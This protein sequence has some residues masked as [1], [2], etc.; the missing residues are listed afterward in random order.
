MFTFTFVAQKREPTIEFQEA[1]RI[2]HYLTCY[3]YKKSGLLSRERIIEKNQFQVPI[4]NAVL[5]VDSIFP[6]RVFSCL[7]SRL[8]NL[9]DARYEFRARCTTHLLPGLPFLVE[10]DMAVEAE[11]STVVLSLHQSTNIAIG[12]DKEESKPIT[13]YVH[14]VTWPPSTMEP[15]FRSR[16]S[17]KPLAHGRNAWLIEW[18]CPDNTS[19]VKLPFES[20]FYSRTAEVTFERNLTLKIEVELRNVPTKLAA[21]IHN[22][23]YCDKWIDSRSDQ[24][25]SLRAQRSV[26]KYD[27]PTP[28]LRSSYQDGRRSSIVSTRSNTSNH[29]IYGQVLAN[30][31]YNHRQVSPAGSPLYHPAASRQLAPHDYFTQA[32]AR[33]R[34]SPSASP[35][36][37]AEAKLT[38]G[39]YNTGAVQLFARA[40]SIRSNS[41]IPRTNAL[42]TMHQGSNLRINEP[43]SEKIT[44]PPASIRSSMSSA[45]E[46]LNV[47]HSPANS[48]G[49][50]TRRQFDDLPAHFE[51]PAPPPSQ[52]LPAAPIGNTAT[53]PIRFTDSST[54]TSAGSIAEHNGDDSSQLTSKSR[55]TTRLSRPAVILGVSQD[56][57]QVH[58][59]AYTRANGEDASP[60]HEFTNRTNSY[61]SA[62]ATHAGE[63]KAPD[64]D[65]GLSEMSFVPGSPSLG[66]SGLVVN[67]TG[68]N[69]RK[70][71]P[72]PQAPAPDDG[73]RVMLG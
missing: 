18:C 30:H 61:N 56:T 66:R 12:A 33:A 55:K 73:G 68:F 35:V 72:P 25:I 20:T 21:V 28:S 29:K 6:D 3:V 7:K 64:R 40:D 53:A 39:S 47:R 9:N 71:P 60:A 27:S 49:S 37:G 22:I 46:A 31:L 52:P 67:S 43:T 5:E 23:I 38:H 41:S 14:E 48:L 54:T 45:F 26:G 10:L 15:H 32:S 59:D 11:I 69:R 36:I 19:K 62:Y 51:N 44:L 42:N 57:I 58:E 8:H 4:T 65:S 13:R 70:E 16:E 63:Q 50:P 17:S 1:G 34:S 2:K 24:S